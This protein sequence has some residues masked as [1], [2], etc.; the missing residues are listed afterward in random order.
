MEIGYYMGD[1]L[2]EVHSLIKLNGFKLSSDVISEFDEKIQDYIK[3]KLNIISSK[4]G[5]YFSKNNIKKSD[6]RDISLEYF[7]MINDNTRLLNILREHEFKFSLGYK[8]NLYVLDKGFSSKFSFNKY[9]N[10][11]LKHEIVFRRFYAS[12]M[13]LEGEER[14]KSIKEFAEIISSK[15]SICDD[16][17]MDGTY[18]EGHFT[19]LLIDPYIKFFGKD[20]LLKSNIRQRKIINSLDAHLNDEELNKVFELLKNYPNFDCKINLSSELLSILTIDEI[21]NMSEKDVFLYKKAMSKNYGLVGR[22]HNVLLLNP[23]FNCS[24]RFIRPE[25]FK[26]MSDEVIAGL[27]AQAIEE[28]EKIKIPFIDNVYVMPIR[29]INRFVAKDERLKKKIE[30]EEAREEAKRHR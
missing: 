26:S 1:V 24:D 11:L 25:I 2:D 21:V 17:T 15:P 6:L 28:I 18:E 29:K 8:L 13:Q 5:P 30:K 16:Y 22:M 14:E 10:M 7:A 4:K 27:S 12:I 9:I 20:F 3:S 19:N 23:S